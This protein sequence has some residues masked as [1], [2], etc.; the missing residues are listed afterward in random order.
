MF[1]KIVLAAW[2]LLVGLGVA[3]ATQEPEF[4]A[5]MT[6]VTG[7]KRITG[8]VYCKEHKTRHEMMEAIT[9]TRLDEKTSY[10]LLPKDKIYMQQ[11][12]DTKSVAQIGALEQG[13]LERISL[14]KERV[15]GRDTE[16]FRVTYANPDGPMVVFQWQDAS[17]IPVKVAAADGSWMVEYSNVVMRPLPDALFEIPKDY[18]AFQTPS[19]PGTG[20]QGGGAMEEM[21]KQMQQGL[22][23]QGGGSGS[24]EA[25]IKQLQGAGAGGA[26]GSNPDELMKQV[27]AMMSGQGNSGDSGNN[28]Q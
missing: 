21:M 5:D 16:K 24:M 23:T 25:M 3:V 13:E 22:N 4:S 11:A 10:I 28:N 20:G 26:S 14:G 7:E 1:R 9:I 15:N 2:M 6:L 8:K 27:E 19:L 12:I 17:E 18:K